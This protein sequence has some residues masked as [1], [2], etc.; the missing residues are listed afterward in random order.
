MCHSHLQIDLGEYINFI[1]G[2]NGSGKSAI[3]TA[4][5]IAFGSRARG[6]QRASTL[7]DFIKTGCSSALVQVEI[8]NQGED[9]YKPD[10]Y[11]GLITIERRIS[12]SS[13]ATVLK[14]SQGRKVAGRKEDL[15]ELVEHFNIDVE[16]PCVIMSQDKSREF[17]HSGNPKEKFKFFFKATLLQQVHDLLLSISTLL[18]DANAQLDEMEATIS[19]ILKE[20]MDLQDKIKSMEQVEEIAQKLDQLKKKLA[21]SWVYDVDKQITVQGSKIEKLKERIPA[22]QLKIESYLR[23]IE[24]IRE[25]LT[26]K[27][28]HISSMME[29]TSVVRKQK[30]E[31]QQ[32]LS[33]AT[34]ERLELEQEY[35]RKNNQI[36]KMIKHV[37]SLEKQ[38]SDIQEQ[39]LRD[40]QAEEC[41][42]EDVLRGLQGEVDT[43]KSSL[44]RLK[45][46]ETALSDQLSI[47]SNTVEKIVLEI[48]DHEK[49]R[50]DITNQIRKLRLHQTDEVT[51]FGGAKVLQLLKAIERHHRG[52]TMPPIGPIGSHVK[53]K[54]EMWGVAAESALGKL[55]NAFI[56]TNHKDSLLLRTCAREAQ[57]FHLQ[58]IIYDFSRPK[59]NIPNHMLP[60]T[61]LPT[62]Y[63]QILTDNPTV[64]NVLVDMGH[65]ERQVLVK[66]YEMGKAVA[67]N[68]RILNLKEVYTSD[69]YKM[70]ARGSVETTLPPNKWTKGGRL[71]RSFDDQIKH[72][73][74]DAMKFE[75]L[76]RQGRGRKRNAEEAVLDLKAKYSSA[77]K[78]HESVE[79]DLISK[80]LE[81]QDIVQDIKNSQSAAARS[82]STS[83]ADELWQEISKLRDEIQ[84]KEGLLER[85][86]VIRTEA[87]AKVKDLKISFEQLCEST[88]HDI[89]IF[90]KAEQELMIIEDSFAEAEKGKAHYELLMQN[91]VLAE[92]EQ[93]EAQHQEL[94]RNRQESCKKAS[95]ICPENEVEALGGCAGSTPE[96]LSAQVKTM[97]QRLQ[98]ENRRHA[99][100]IDDLRALHDKKERKIARKKARFAAFREKLRVC[101][102][103]LDLRWNKFQRNASLSK[104]Q[105]TWRFNGHLGKK[106]ISG[107]I[108]VSYEEKTLAVEVK[109]PQDA[110]SNTVRDTRGLSGGERS[111]STLCFA[112]A[113]HEMAEA[114]F[115]AM[116]EFDVF[117][118]AVSRKISLDTV[119]DFALTQGSQWIFITPHDIS[120][121]KQHERVK[122][123]QMAAPRG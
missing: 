88:K 104:R 109:M 96:L 26:E 75:E 1:T 32:S 6:T 63:S 53:L 44:T 106:G 47:A 97:H 34:K 10:V 14:D 5:C 72:Y 42:M 73:E 116:D 29:M 89:D 54:N 11:G 59:L 23:K 50:R 108:K 99:E 101:Q 16:N 123:Q 78:R 9:A 58:I 2:Q 48:E 67:F 55:L 45:E 76:V 68:Q 79:K 28:A 117:M 20:L 61:H 22:C 65:A 112:L 57:Y 100:S 118:D 90:E 121:V 30:D 60:D 87:E 111:F 7:K 25:D 107:N 98:Q 102:E 40:T 12:E 115:R 36:Q 38:V 71:S 70:F 43:A 84:E 113:L 17:L 49:R 94:Q 33:L 52:F 74:N 15:H 77:K 122:K 4:L 81:V 3:L 119:V 21:W 80:Q 64:S 62:T 8:K 24:E 39:H 114:P 41:Q 69:G 86:H 92:I 83:N 35:S 18:S 37:K 93:A 27:K 85:Y 13:S 91:K 120:M 82:S 19:P 105:L 31:L 95:I 46:E 110:S 66:D 56:V 103:G 51:A